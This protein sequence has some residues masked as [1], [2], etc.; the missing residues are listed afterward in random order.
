MV[1]AYKYPA[2]PLD[3]PGW[4][5]RFA[6]TAWTEFNDDGSARDYQTFRANLA[7][8]RADDLSAAQLTISR[9]Q[10]PLYR[11][12]R[13][14]PV[15]LLA[16]TKQRSDLNV[17]RYD[18][19]GI[20]DTSGWI[21]DG[22]QPVFGYA[23]P[24]QDRWTDVT[25][26]AN[27]IIT[28]SR[29]WVASVDFRYLLGSLQFRDDPFE[30]PN[31]PKQ[32]VLL[33]NGQTDEEIV[34]WAFGLYEDR[35]WLAD[36]WGTPF[37]YPA[38]STE[39]YRQFLVALYEARLRGE[40]SRLGLSQALAGAT[41]RPVAQAAET[42]LEALEDAAGWFVATASRIYR[43]A[44]ATVPSV[45]VGDELAPGQFLDADLSVTDFRLE[46]A[47]PADLQALMTGP[48]LLPG[49]YRYPLGWPNRE[50]SVTAFTGEDGFT[51]VR[52]ELL[53]NPG[54]IDQFFEDADAV[55]EGS[56]AQMLDARPDPVGDPLPESVLPTVNPA[57]FL[58]DSIY[59]GDAVLV[60]WHRRSGQTNLPAGWLSQI[61]AVWP[62][63]ILLLVQAIIDVGDMAI[64]DA[65]TGFGY[66]GNAAGADAGS[67]DVDD[68]VT[69]FDLFYAG[70]SS[71]RCS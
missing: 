47:L 52:F 10:T 62:A 6:G 66:A 8:Q 63:G 5:L 22:T 17:F 51:K 39:F 12:L 4:L 70:L 24:W 37:A 1:V 21:Y 28:P 26:L 49:R 59:L 43:L 29:T 60:R 23:F 11:R 34:L 56:L 25:L 48:G 3:Q 53:G 40:I 33:D 61:K 13:W 67:Q 30:D 44:P 15:R 7:R 14:L 64:D 65:N 45:A 31:V 54:D 38:A 16:S 41:G 42:V 18:A 46:D 55:T 36:R 57:Q 68:S 35:E 20:Y 71:G 19:E 69:G 50:V 9:D 32:T 58:L 27:R 2:S